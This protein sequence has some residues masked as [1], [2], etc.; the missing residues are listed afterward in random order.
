M[1]ARCA[2]RAVVANRPDIIIKNRTKNCLLVDVAIPSER[3]VIQ[4]E[5][6]KNENIKSKYRNSANVE[7][8]MLSHS[9]KHCD[10]WICN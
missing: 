6:G 2:Y 8:G 4:N 3:N 7:Y 9:S 5:A 10:H 1:E